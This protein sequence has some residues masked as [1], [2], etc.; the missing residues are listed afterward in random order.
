MKQAA[1]FEVEEIRCSK[2]VRWLQLS[3]AKKTL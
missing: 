2:I 1:F 3:K